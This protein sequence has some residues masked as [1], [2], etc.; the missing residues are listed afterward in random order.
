VAQR[1][2]HAA[3]ALRRAVTTGHDYDAAT[4]ELLAAATALATLRGGPT[5]TEPTAAIPDSATETGCVAH[6]FEFVAIDVELADRSVEFSVELNPVGEALDADDPALQVVVDH[7]PEPFGL[8]EEDWIANVLG[9]E[10]RREFEHR[11]AGE[12]RQTGELTVRVRGSTTAF[13]PS[14]ESVPSLSAVAAEWAICV[15]RYCI[16]T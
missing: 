10:W 11:R 9:S 8:I 12:G 14:V 5:G 2:E 15:L 7:R 6:P 16:S 13:A 1:A 3:V 4:A